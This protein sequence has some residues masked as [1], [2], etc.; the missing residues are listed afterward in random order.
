MTVTKLLKPDDV[1]ATLHVERSTAVSGSLRRD[2]PWIKVGNRL[3][4]PAEA[5]EQY[6]ARG[7]HVLKKP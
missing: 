6:L 2:L 5:L 4:L 7:G 3:R 1:A